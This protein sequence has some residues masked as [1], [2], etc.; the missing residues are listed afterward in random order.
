MTTASAKNWREEFGIR[1]K[2]AGQ[3]YTS[4]D[5]LRDAEGHVPQAH[6]LRRAF[7]Q[8]K[9]DGILCSDSSPLVYFKEVAEISKEEA[10]RL[11][12]D[13]WNHGAAPI[14][15]LIDPQKVHIYSGLS[16]PTQY[17]DNKGK[18]AGFVDEL[19]RASAALKEFLPSVE[20]GEFFRRHA[21]S[22]DPKQR[23]DRDLLDNLQATRRDLVAALQRDVK[24]DVLDALLCRLVFA[25]YL[26]DRAVI[27]AEYLATIG[28]TGA[29]HL[30]DVLGVKPRYVAKD[31]L[32]NKLFK[33]LGTD[34][35]G[36]LFSGN[37]EA[38]ADLIAATHLD[39][40]EG[41]FRGTKAGQAAFWPYNFA[42]IPIETISAIYERFLKE[43]DRNKGA[44]Y[45]PR[46]LVEVVLDAA[47]TRTRSLLGKKYLDPACGSGVF[48]VGLFNRM[49]EEWS[50]AHPNANND[51]RAR[52]LMKLLQESLYGIDVNPTACRISA[53]SLYLA[54]LDQLSP[55]GIR[56]IQE[57]KGALPYLV[58]SLPGEKKA[59]SG[60]NIWQ[61]D[62]F[63]KVDRY[64][65]DVHLVV[66]NPP[67]GSIAE[68]GSPAAVWC[69]EQRP[70]VAIPDKQ[71][72]AAFMW[73]AAL[74]AAG[75]GS[76]CL[77]L[78]H[79]IIFNHSR[80]ALDF[81]ARFLQRFA[82]DQVLNLV[83]YQYFLFAEARQ[84]AV[85]MSYRPCPPRAKEH[86]VEYWAPKADWMVRR[87]EV[88]TVGPEDRSK[89]TV[90]DVLDDLQADDAPQIWKRRMWASP[91]D[92]RLIERLASYPRL[93]DRVR[94]PKD[95]GSDKPW[96]MAEGFQPVGKGDDPDEASVLELP[97]KLFIKAKSSKIKLFLLKDD[98]AELPNAEKVI[99]AGSNKQTEIFKAPH[100]LVSQGFTR[101]AFADFDV[102]F[103]HALRGICGKKSD[104]ELLI[105]LSAY[106]RSPLA[107]YFL[108]HTSSNWGVSRQKA[109]V[110]ELLR[111]PFPVPNDQ[112][113][114]KGCWKIVREV[115]A[116][117][118][119][120]A[121][122]AEKPIAD[123]DD[124]VRR[125]TREIEPLLDRYFD[126]LPE[127]QVLVRDTVKIII[128]SVRPTAKRVKVPTIVQ[129]DGQWR[130]TYTRRLCDTL[131]RWAR[132]SGFVIKGSQRGSP[133]LGIGVC[134]L[135]RGLRSE[136]RPAPE[137][138]TDLLEVLDELH[139]T[140]ARKCNAFEL[141]RGLKAFHGD[142]LYVVKR[143][144]QRYW[145][146]TA[147]LNDADEI[148]GSLLMQVPEGVA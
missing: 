95:K 94:Q 6:V 25:C 36:D 112:E 98:C 108:F 32:Y 46:F 24:G 127:E 29:A 88:I 61:G 44:F 117:V 58:A 15:V 47:L 82:V 133:M 110:E 45:T 11:Q 126:V 101:T 107:R 97:S 5:D 72:A 48:L 62:F 59:K 28:I 23:V 92:W 136:A 146:E 90:K 37:L 52:E 14:F 1:R 93:R 140:V 78:P 135:Q 103:Q 26:F 4:K 80:P 54:Y 76:V 100:V 105:F 131:N 66:G 38:E 91:R 115:A 13:F 40:L 121:A 141:A 87:A 84:P 20:S 142:Q 43:S 17:G 99:R 75:D 147:A 8:L 139:K 143:L 9:L 128:P 137:V 77:V 118:E 35:N 122:A 39:L 114:S 56:E 119:S 50:Q 120:A 42:V 86:I 64:P 83:D 71:I 145:T 129:S 31:L 96:L 102:S 111:L 106:L 53:F 27:D 55:R 67:W 10:I 57:K 134:V 69:G 7:D 123:R 70:P 104:R 19:K 74:H 2:R 125:A 30:R 113:N 73:K 130:D 132:R 18:S 34:F 60:N 116:I 148:A 79:G 65:V 16:R 22:F 3:F 21:K 49:A 138:S 124:I 89:F 33:N 51:V 81:Q 144:G 63:D 85:V 12:N 68:E 41:F 109:H